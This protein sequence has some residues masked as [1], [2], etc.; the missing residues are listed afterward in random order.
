[1]DWVGL[2]L[3]VS[4]P[5]N[6]SIRLQ[7]RKLVARRKTIVTKREELKKKYAAAAELRTNKVVEISELLAIPP[8]PRD[9]QAVTFIAQWRETGR[10]SVPAQLKTKA[11]RLLREWRSIHMACIE[12]QDEL[13]QLDNQRRVTAAERPLSILGR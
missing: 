5:D 12:T 6:L 10:V 4:R 9:E 7:W 11:E 8:D 13:E 3:C 2:T 1:V